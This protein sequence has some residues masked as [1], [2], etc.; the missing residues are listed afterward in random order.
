[1][2]IYVRISGLG[3]QGAVTA[4]HILGGAAVM[5]GK[6]ALVNPFFGAEKRLAPAESYVRVS[7]EQ[8]FDTGEILYPDV[9]LIFHPDVILQG[10]S[11]TMPFFSGIK[12]DGIIIVNSPKAIRFT[13][14][15]E[16][17][18]N[19]LN[20]SVYFIPATEIAKQVGGTELST[21]IAMLGALLGITNIVSMD[22]MQGSLK[23]RFGGKVKFVASGSTA[24]LD[25]H[26]KKQYD[27]V[28]KLI[29]ANM[30]VLSEAYNRGET[31]VKT[32][33]KQRI[34]V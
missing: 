11:Y 33:K 29:A 20:V 5:D 19:E 17:R 15:E 14:D 4:A 18:L 24:A 3:G 12:R 30:D 6:N 25:D 22:A 27:K 32:N 2:Q 28:E 8:I 9:I 7:D 23:E 21:N 13:D 16:R 1:M 10:K 26:I 31:L 34:E